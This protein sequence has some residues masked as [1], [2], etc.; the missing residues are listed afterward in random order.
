MSF[1]ASTIIISQTICLATCTGSCPITYFISLSVLSKRYLHL[2]SQAFLYSSFLRATFSRFL[3]WFLSPTICKS[4]RITWDI[5]YISDW[6][7][8]CA[9]GGTTC[10]LGSFYFYFISFS[11]STWFSLRAFSFSNKSTIYFFHCFFSSANFRI[12]SLQS[13]ISSFNVSFSFSISVSSKA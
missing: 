1:V 5:S 11:N 13:F 2:C 9:R 3:F 4:L 8:V 10:T 7:L 6:S 12:F